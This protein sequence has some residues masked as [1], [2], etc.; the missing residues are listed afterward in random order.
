MKQ[1]ASADYEKMIDEGG[2]TKIL[3]NP[4]R[5]AG[6]NSLDPPVTGDCRLPYERT[7]RTAQGRGKKMMLKIG[8]FSSLSQVSIKALRFYDEVGLLKPTFV[9]GATGYRYYSPNLLTRLNRILAFKD[10]GFSLDEI[11]LLLREDLTPDAVREALHNKRKDLSGRIAIEQARLARVDSLLAQIKRA[12]R[13][14]SYEITLRQLAP[15]WVAS[16]RDCLS[17]YD[18]ASELFT[19][20]KRYLKRHNANG[21][22]AARWH[23]CA[24]KGKQ[25]DCEAMVLL[26]RPIP[27]SK[28]IDVYEL[29]AGANACVIHDG[30]DETLTEAYGAAH[31]WIKS[32]GYRIDGPPCEL[33]WQGGVAQSNVSGVTEIR[34]PILKLPAHA[35]H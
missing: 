26:G 6:L 23:V 5:L 3:Q 30:S 12:G 32:N 25:I 31:S 13:V 27:K 33:Y 1:E 2:M 28:R 15:Q 8:D 16:I 11:T 14:P 21:R 22:E 17:S 7:N 35:G 9:D 10:L 19:E 29:P 24:G 20:L 18:D 34:Y 4:H